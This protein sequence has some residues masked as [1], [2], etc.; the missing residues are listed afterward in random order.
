MGLQWLKWSGQW[1]TPEQEKIIFKAYNLKF[2]EKEK[3]K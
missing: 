1:T 2:A 3:D